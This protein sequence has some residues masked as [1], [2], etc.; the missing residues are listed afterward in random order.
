MAQSAREVAESCDVTV[1]MLADP[2]AARAV[3]SEVAAGLSPGIACQHSACSHQLL[4]CAARPFEITGRLSHHL[5]I[6]HADG[7]S[8]AVTEG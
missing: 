2:A 8:K 1:A 4:L 5:L 7:T 6:C 3:A